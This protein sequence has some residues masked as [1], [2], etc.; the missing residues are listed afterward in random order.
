VQRVVGRHGG[1]VWA[2]G[3]VG[4]GAT[5]YFTLLTRPASHPASGDTT[6]GGEIH[7]LGGR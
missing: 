3:S 2:E 5:F 1:R 6:H 4:R 7:A